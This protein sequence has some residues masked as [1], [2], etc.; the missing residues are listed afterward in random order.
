MPSL[1][2]YCQGVIRHT[3]ECQPSADTA[4]GVIRYRI[5]CQALAELPRRDNIKNSIP[6][7]GIYCD[8][9][10]QSIDQS[11]ASS[12]CKVCLASRW[13]WES[14]SKPSRPPRRIL[15]IQPKSQTS[16]L[17]LSLHRGRPHRQFCAFSTNCR[18][19][20]GWGTRSQRGCRRH[21]WR[22]LSAQGSWSCSSRRSLERTRHLAAAQR[23]IGNDHGAPAQSKLTQGDCASLQRLGRRVV[24]Q[25]HEEQGT[26]GSKD[27]FPAIEAHSTVQHSWLQPCPRQ[28]HLSLGSKLRTRGKNS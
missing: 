23:S 9:T 26:S 5:A 8:H 24:L 6:S 14:S 25:I 4:K 1:S 20:W 15:S 12:I 17:S 18:R 21:S 22:Q 28:D 11:T 27:H 10:M 13:S 3:T 2:R 19:L 16:T 7:L